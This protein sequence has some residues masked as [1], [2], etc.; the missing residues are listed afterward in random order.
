M[1]TTLF[2]SLLFCLPILGQSSE[3]KRDPLPQAHK[4]APSF[5]VPNLRHQKTGKRLL[6]NPD[7]PP[8]SRPNRDASF[9]P[10]AV[11][12]LTYQQ[13]RRILPVP[14]T[15][16]ANARGKTLVITVLNKSS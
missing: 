3:E 8:L 2:L 10:Q 9:S 13:D 11:L 5:F 14:K 16:M 12:I 1:K 7:S 4:V 15:S 6:E